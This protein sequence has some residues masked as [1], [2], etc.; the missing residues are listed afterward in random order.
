MDY[1]QQVIQFFTGSLVLQLLLY[2]FLMFDA[3]FK[4]SKYRNEFDLW[5]TLQDGLIW[6]RRKVLPGNAPSWMTA[7][8]DSVCI[9]L[10]PLL[11]PFVLCALVIMTAAGIGYAIYEART[12]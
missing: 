10:S 4:F 3:R 1:S 7:I 11:T 6:F 9:V 12:C 8:F 5:H 2:Y